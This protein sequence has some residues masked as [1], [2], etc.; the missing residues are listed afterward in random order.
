MPEKWHNDVLGINPKTINFYALCE[1][2]GKVELITY[3]SS[4]LPERLVGP[5]GRMLSVSDLM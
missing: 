2:L 4:D 5:W 3:D 1:E